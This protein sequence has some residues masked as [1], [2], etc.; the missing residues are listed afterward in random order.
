MPA[1]DLRTIAT[2]EVEIELA[3]EAYVA[4]VAAGALARANAYIIAYATY[5]PATYDLAMAARI[6]AYNETKVAYARLQTLCDE[7]ATLNHHLDIVMCDEEAGVSGTMQAICLCGWILDNPAYRYPKDSRD[8]RLIAW[9]A[10]EAHVREA[11]PDA[12]A[13]WSVVGWHYSITAPNRKKSNLTD[14]AMF[15][16][17]KLAREYIDIKRI[18]LPDVE[19]IM[20]LPGD[21]QIDLHVPTTAE[22]DQRL[23]IKQ[24]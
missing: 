16:T 3:K 20:L 19:R 18:M 17:I 23:A 21:R 24:F 7:L 14:P 22:R 11:H 6:V 5:D 13:C 1:A 10:F 12:V 2:I 4:A 8:V 9:D 15:S